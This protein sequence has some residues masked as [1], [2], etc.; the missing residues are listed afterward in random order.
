[1]EQQQVKYEKVVDDV[2]LA[3]DNKNEKVTPYFILFDYKS[4]RI[5]SYVIYV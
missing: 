3:N 1:M 4:D 5:L 2:V